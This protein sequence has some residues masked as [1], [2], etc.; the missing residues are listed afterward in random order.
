MKI[1]F[2]FISCFDFSYSMNTGG[3][4]LCQHLLHDHDITISSAKADEKQRKINEVFFSSAS[5]TSNSYASKRKSCDAN[6]PFMFFRQIVLWFCRDL[7]PLCTVEKKGFNDF[8]QYL[9]KTQ[10][11]PSRST[12]SISALDD[13]YLCCKNKL[14]EKLSNSTQ[15]A[16]ITFDGWSDRH[17]R[18]SYFTY[19]YHF[20]ENWKMKSVVL[21][22]AHFPRPHTGE[23]VKE[24]FE[25]T[26]AEFNVLNKR[27]SVV[28]DG[29][30]E[31][32]KAAKLLKLYRFHCIGHILHLLIRVDLLQND[33]MAPLRDLQDKLRKIHRKLIY[34]HEQLSEIENE[35]TR[36]KIMNILEEHREMGKSI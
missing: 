23:R 33:G 18:I 14:I 36:K 6:S 2:E 15:H 17:K 22:T 20:M 7:L 25:A 31:M 9:N 29:G 3:T 11:L 19:T 28:T 35:A 30:S 12:V 16:T 4:N 21:K 26:L 24:D 32:K 5:T 8:F 1:I 34:K 10:E 27:L 13:L